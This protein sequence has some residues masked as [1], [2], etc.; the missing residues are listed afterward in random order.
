MS[1]SSSE[2][3]MLTKYFDPLHDSTLHKVSYE[4]QFK[5]KKPLFMRV[6]ESGNSAYN[7]MPKIR[8]IPRFFGMG[9]AYQ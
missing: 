8:G 2:W 9:C 7:Y 6:C 3:D 4:D 5:I 1:F